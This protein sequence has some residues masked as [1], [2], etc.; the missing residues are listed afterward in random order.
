M[1]N[2]VFRKKDRTSSILMFSNNSVKN[3]GCGS[4]FSMKAWVS[5]VWPMR[6][7]G[8]TTCS[9]FDALK[10]GLHSPKVGW[11]RKSLLLMFMLHRCC[12]FL[13]R[14][15][16]II[17][18]KSVYGMEIA[19]GFRF[20]ADL[21]TESDLSF[22]LTPM[23]L[24]IQHKIIFIFFEFLFSIINHYHINGLHLFWDSFEWFLSP[25]KSWRKIFFPHL[26]EALWS[27]INCCHSI[28]FSNLK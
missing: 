12:H 3:C 13:R 24:G 1:Y 4:C 6:S 20:K 22:P 19:L 11:I 26:S 9:L 10:A 8:I 14:N 21:A 16:L 23:W 15:L 18:F 7:R 17:G 5:L 2:P 27:R 28:L 25:N